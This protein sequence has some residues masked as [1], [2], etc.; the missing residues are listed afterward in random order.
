MVITLAAD[1]EFAAEYLANG[2]VK[3]KGFDVQVVWPE[4][5]SPP[6]YEAI[7]AEPMYNISVLPLSNFLIAID[8]G[9]PVT[10]IPVFPDVFFPH[11]G[12]QVNKRAGIRTAKDLEGKRVG[13][14]GYGF[15]P[16]TW[17][18]GALA[19]VY[20]VDLTRITWV[21]SAPNSLS[22][23]NYPRPARFKVEKGGDPL[24]ELERGALDAVFHARVG[25]LLTEH[26]TRLFDDPLREALK[27]YR[28]TGV[29]PVNTVLVARTDTLQA[30]PGLAQAIVAACD[31]ARDLYYRNAKPFDSHT[32]FPIWWLTDHG[33]FPHRNGVEN[34]RQALET[35]IRYAHDSGIIR[36][37]PAV[38]DLFFE[39]AR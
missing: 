36:G 18:R 5:G 35:I 17:L 11:V 10:G 8:Q 33:M 38:E 22:L 20:D 2:M 13:I 26:T 30:N 14:S 37:K 6:M 15:N 39:G 19:D 16:A 7:F 23:A 28:Q 12:A 9:R 31:E 3:V 27:Y 32:G 1:H 24:Q 25:P 29:L 34:N 21:E 4:R